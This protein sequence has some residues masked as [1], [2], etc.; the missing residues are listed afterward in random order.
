MGMQLRGRQALA[1]A[2]ALAAAAVPANIAAPA[3][4]AV[5][6]TRTGT[7]FADVITG[8]AGPDVLCGLGGA[9]TLKGL[10]GDDILIGGSGADT[11][12][13][14]DGDDQL[15]GGDANDSLTGGLGADV[16]TGGAGSDLARYDERYHPLI[17]SVGRGAD[18][19]A[20][21]EGD[22][23]HADVER[24]YGGSAYDKIVTYG[25]APVQ[26]L[27]KGGNDEL[28][29]GPGA[30]KLQGD[31]GN[32]L[33]IGVG[34]VDT[35]NCGAGV[36]SYQQ[37]G[38]D[39]K[40]F[41]CEQVAPNRAPTPTTDY[42]QTFED[43]PVQVE[44]STLLANDADP[45]HDAVS[46]VGLTTGPSFARGTAVLS[47][48]TITFTPI[49]DYDGGSGTGS[50][51][52]TVT[53]GKTSAS[54]GVSIAITAVN[55]APVAVD[56]EASVAQDGSVAIP[57]ADLLANDR[58]IDSAKQLKAVHDPL[59]GAVSIAPASNQSER[60]V[61]FT[62]T[63]GYC[64]P[65]GFDYTL[66]DGSL[67]DVGH[68]GVAVVCSPPPPP[69]PPPP[70]IFT[71]KDELFGFE[72]TLLTV[73]AEQLLANDEDVQGHPLTVV[74][75]FSNH[76]EA[77]VEGDTVYL[78]PDPE[79]CNAAAG[80]SP[81]PFDL[82]YVVSDGT[83][84]EFGTADVWLECVNDAP[85]TWF[86][87]AT[88]ERN[89]PLVLE[90]SFFDGYDLDFDPLTVSEVSNPQHGTVS[91]TNG[92]VTFMPEQDYCGD[93]AGFDFTLSDGR[94]GATDHVYVNVWGRDC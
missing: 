27:G 32:D 91:V 81:K 33:L 57:V 49:A 40:Q 90:S 50:F 23:V 77:W 3:S 6:C 28:I 69:P 35:Y 67:T 39:I 78:Q 75:A 61:V 11:L 85:V 36:D 55:D 66:S 84:I 21:G 60:S 17:I 72:D 59:H 26:F 53:D 48:S 9:D 14:G 15:D 52:Y 93:E 56:D 80:S 73:P 12:Q 42:L 58:D 79:D 47:G 68:V 44:V 65:A 37:D 63:A 16:L 10:G 46:F 74:D 86:Q 88:V 18:D 83:E 64:G 87:L 8:T 71:G 41:G 38:K 20:P 19:G 45:D 4:S 13:G 51:F 2:V 31:A 34:A 43:T 89:T 29:G 92:T 82:L 1:T 24:V 94:L 54:G 62:P 5:T 7:A 76:G 25:T 30:D 70:H 22:N